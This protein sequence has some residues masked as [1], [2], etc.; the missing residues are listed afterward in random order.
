M[1]ISLLRQLSYTK[2]DNSEEE[3]IIC[4]GDFEVGDEI[5]PFPD[6]GHKYH[7]SCL[8]EWLKNKV[9]CPMCRRGAR[10]SLIKAMSQRPNREL[11]ELINYE[12][13]Q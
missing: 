12:E 6:C 8:L 5:Q 13:D 1:E 4:L 2:R 10:S 3:C 11:V 7:P 9:N